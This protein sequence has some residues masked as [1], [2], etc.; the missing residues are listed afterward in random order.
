M[1]SWFSIHR[2]IKNH[3][4]FQEERKFSKFEAWFFI[5][6]ETNFA[7]GKVPIGNQIVS[8]KR[9]EFFTSKLKLSEKFGWSRKKLDAF[10]RALERDNMI[11]I[12]ST[13]KYTL[14]TVVNYD[15]YQ[16]NEGRNAQQKRQQERQQS[17]QQPHN[18][19]TSNAQQLH[20]TNKKKEFNNVNNL[21]SAAGEESNSSY[22]H[23]DKGHEPKEKTN[24]VDLLNKYGM[25]DNKL[26]NKDRM[27][28]FELHEKV[29]DKYFIRAI[30]KA[31]TK[32]APTANYVLGILRR[33]TEGGKLTYEDLEKQPV[34]TY[35]HRSRNNDPIKRLRE[36]TEE[37]VFGGE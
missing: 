20:T 12:K 14:I 22:E 9:G 13:T 31:K 25:P 32:N 7:D 15:F 3:W 1:S 33:E 35:G 8:V 30:E 24:T 2:S 26:G 27:E 36:L 16:G 34:K 19:R 37:D 5:L 23:V 6:M 10:L 21:Y 29:K 28:L 17:E 18:N 4:L 11:H